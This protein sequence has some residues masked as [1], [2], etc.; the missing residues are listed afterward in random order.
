MRNFISSLGSSGGG[1][2]ISDLNYYVAKTGSDLNNGSV[3]TPFLTINKAVDTVKGL[4]ASNKTGDVVVSISDGVYNETLDLGLADSGNNALKITYK[5]IGSNVIV[6]GSETGQGVTDNAGIWEFTIPSNKQRC[7][8]VYANGERRTRARNQGFTYPTA[9]ATTQIITQGSGNAAELV[10][11]TVAINPTIA[12]QL[13]SLSA[14]ELSEAKIYLFLRWNVMMSPIESVNTGTNTITFLSKGLPAYNPILTSTPIFFE[15]YVDAL[16]EEGT[17]LQN[18]TTF[19]YKPMLGETIG[20]T[21][22]NVPVENKLLQVN[23]TDLNNR[24]EN[25]HFESI[26]FRYA[27][28]ELPNNRFETEQAANQTEGNIEFNY[29]QATFKGCTIEK[30]GQYALSFN[31]GCINSVIE[32]NTISDGGVGGIRV[33]EIYPTNFLGIINSDPNKKTEYITLSNNNISNI[34]RNIACGCGILIG[35]SGNNTVSHNEVSGSFYSSLSMGWGWS[36][37]NQNTFAKNNLV[38]W[39]KF[40]NVDGTYLN[41]LGGIYTTGFASG[42]VVRNNV[43]HDISARSNDLGVGIYPDQGTSGILYENNLLYN[44]VKASLHNNLGYLNTFTNNVFC[45]DDLNLLSYNRVATGGLDLNKNIFFGKTGTNL[46]IGDWDDNTG[47][48]DYNCYY[49][50]NGSAFTFINGWTFNQWQTNTGND[51]NSVIQNP[52]TLDEIN[53]TYII[54]EATKTAIGI[55]QVDWTLAGNN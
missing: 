16:T 9:N 27:S 45:L 22:F 6:D 33:G 32:N 12:A 25:V 36:G 24:V 51:A 50:E 30:Y 28:L 7:F 8:D 48:M 40:T 54:N 31:Y 55:V 14:S 3:S 20:N 37:T 53:E 11:Y 4:V 23:G 19:Y 17:W 26:K 42:T 43:V 49:F 29:A 39:N 47:N 18:G 5:G 13:G 10:R 38:E 15:N 35:D 1:V 21:T 46:M 41:D 44:T 52:G 34:G 2:L